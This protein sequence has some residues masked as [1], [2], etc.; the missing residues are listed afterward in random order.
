LAQQRGSYVAAAARMK[1]LGTIQQRRRRLI[2]F[3]PARCAPFCDRNATLDDFLDACVLLLHNCPN[4]SS[5]N[6]SG[7]RNR[8][9]CENQTPC[10]GSVYRMAS[11]RLLHCGVSSVL[12]SPLLK[13]CP[14]LRASLRGEY[15]LCVGSHSIARRQLW[16]SRSE[17]R[18]KKGGGY[19]QEQSTR[20]GSGRGGKCGRSRGEAATA[21]LGC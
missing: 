7:H 11:N 19:V 21:T 20:E 15:R 18:R 2:P 8:C 16:P 17:Y 12:H 4:L 6:R 5:Q 14:N 13:W 10:H 9:R 3:S 1:E